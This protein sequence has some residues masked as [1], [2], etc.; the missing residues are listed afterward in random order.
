METQSA[1]GE[2]DAIS[3]IEYRGRESGVSGQR[4]LECAGQR[5]GRGQGAGWR[6]SWAGDLGFG[7]WSRRGEGRHR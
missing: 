6:L 3:Q 2:E 7:H 5:K 4:P 1:S